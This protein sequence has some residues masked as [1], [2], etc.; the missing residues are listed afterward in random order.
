MP[1][2]HTPA[3]ASKGTRVQIVPLVSVRQG[4]VGTMVTVPFR[5]ANS[6]L[7]A[8][9][10]MAGPAR[11]VMRIVPVMLDI[12]KTAGRV[13]L[14]VDSTCHV[15]ARQIGAEQPVPLVG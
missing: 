6:L 14:E 10:L 4:I 3:S 2:V 15:N 11:D 9:A 12:V 7:S 8:R 13:A 5:Q 1:P